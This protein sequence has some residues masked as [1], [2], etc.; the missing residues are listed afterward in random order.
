MQPDCEPKPRSRKLG[1]SPGGDAIEADRKLA[2][3]GKV[4][5]LIKQPLLSAALAL[6]ASASGAAPNVLWIHVEDQHPWYGAYGETRV[7]TPNIDALAREGVVFERAYAATPVCS[8]SRSANITGT[9]PIRAG[10]HDHRSGRVPGNRIELP[11]GMATV[12][13]LF[14]RHGYAT[15]NNGKDDYNFTYDRGALYSIGTTRRNEPAGWKGEAGDGDWRDVPEGVPF[16]GQIGTLGGKAAP[17][18]DSALKAAGVPAVDPAGVTVPPQYP[19]LAGLRDAIAAHLDTMVDTDN[20]VGEVMARLKADDLWGNTIVVLFSDHGSNLPRSK[21]FCYDEGLKVPLIIAAPGLADIVRPGTR[22]GDLVSLMD[23][24]ATS[25]A[26]AG[27]AVPD[28]MDSKDVF[29]PDYQRPYVFSSQDRMSNTIDRVRSVMGPRFHYIRNFLTDRPLYQFGYREM[30]ALGQPDH[31]LNTMRR[32]YES[33]TLTTAQALPY[34][35]R[36]AEELYDLASDPDELVNLAADPA[37][38]KTLDDMR[39]ALTGW[40]DA[41]GDQAQKPRSAAAMREITER[42]PEDW[43]RGPEFRQRRR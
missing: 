3:H 1:A 38:R 17:R 41:T 12:P 28:T 7:A 33:G 27:I 39:D 31:Y 2:R 4:T 36:P 19:D 26:L 21:E 9:Y 13:E 5:R 16:F 29:D 43:L 34:G 42:Y 14:R 30:G 11:A 6:A 22:R 20:R 15:F 37:H 32:M 18:V 35:P 24:A 8:P 40:I 25:L 10:T 23:I